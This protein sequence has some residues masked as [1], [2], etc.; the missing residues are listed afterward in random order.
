MK[1]RAIFGI[2]GFVLTIAV[3]VPVLFFLSRGAVS[4]NQFVVITSA[5][6]LLVLWTIPYVTLVD[7]LLRRGVGALFNVTI[8]WRGTSKSI[9]WTPV[10][11]MGCL[12]GLFIDLLGYFFIILWLLPFGAAVAMVLWLRHGH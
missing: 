7:P 10:E 2:A 1:P 4:T 12:T 8:E 9:S 3:M 6:L 11:D 5:V